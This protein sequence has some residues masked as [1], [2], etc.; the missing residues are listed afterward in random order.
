MPEKPKT[1]GYLIDR[2][3]AESNPERAADFMSE[4]YDLLIRVTRPDMWAVRVPSRDC[5]ITLHPSESGEGGYA[6]TYTGLE[7]EDGDEIDAR[8]LAESGTVE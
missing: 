5:W 4:L 6:Q 8:I 1:I 2:I 3:A 7:V